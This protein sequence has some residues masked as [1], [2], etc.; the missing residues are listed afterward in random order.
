LEAADEALAGLEAVDEATAG[1]E[2][3]DE[4]AA[5]LDAVDKAA[6]GLDAVDEA[7][8]SLDAVDKAAAGLEAVD[9]A[10]AGLETADEAAANSEAVGDLSF[11]L[12]IWKRLSVW[13]SSE[14][15][16]PDAKVGIGLARGCATV[17]GGT[18]LVVNTSRGLY[19]RKKHTKNISSKGGER[20][21]DL[22]LKSVVADALR[23]VASH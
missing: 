1:L 20:L 22:L 15:V 4:A 2:A 18:V 16:G 6:A 5:G 11:S 12:G 9:E 10:A 7:A 23:K 14:M 17:P 21:S 3:V 8:A 13:I 19:G